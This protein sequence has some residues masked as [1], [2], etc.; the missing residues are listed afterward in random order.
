MQK[1]DFSCK[2]IHALQNNETILCVYCYRITPHVLF[3][4]IPMKRRAFLKYVFRAATAGTSIWFLM[5][6]TAFAKVLSVFG[7]GRKVDNA[8]PIPPFQ[9]KSFVKQNSIRCM[10]IGDWGTGDAF[11]KRIASS[12]QQY[13][14]KEESQFIISTGDNFYPV[15]VESKNDAQFRTKWENMYNA[16]ALQVP[17]YLVLGNHDYL[18]NPDAQTE[19]NAINQRWNMP[20][21]YY[22]FTKQQGNLSVQFFMLDTEVLH[23]DKTTEITAQLAWLE[24]ELKTSTAHWKVAVGHHIIRSYGVYGEQSFMIRQVKPLLDKYGVQ[25]Y[26][27]GHEH[28]I[29]YLKSP[30]DSFTCVISGGGGGARNTSYGP[31]TRYANTNGGFVGLSFTETSI[32]A[33]FLDAQGTIVYADDIA[34]R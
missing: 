6:D 31:N 10:V 9:V 25:A 17:W 18:S 33:H 29:Q 21:R 24:K 3:T 2:P 20:A 15:G 13:A 14:E 19:Y 26:I 1:C 7:K 22:T 32:N 5:R 16:A 28:D 27:N 4:W 30:D 23:T 11:Q 34:T 8:R 12:M